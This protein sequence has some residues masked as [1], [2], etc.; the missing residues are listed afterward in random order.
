M[1]YFTP[2]FYF[3]KVT[4]YS[5]KIICKTKNFTPKNKTFT[6]NLIFFHKARNETKHYQISFYTKSEVLYTKL[7]ALLRFRIYFYT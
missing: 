4:P 6:L 2:K 7:M 3:K 5:E 1:K